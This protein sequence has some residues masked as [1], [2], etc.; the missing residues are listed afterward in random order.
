VIALAVRWYVRYRLSSADVAEWLA[1]RGIAVD[2]STV[3]RW[4]QRC[5]PRFVE[6]ARA[7]RTPVDGR[8]RVDETYGR[9]HGRW[10]SLYRAIDQNGQVVA[11]SFSERRNAE[12]ATAFFRRAIATSGVTPA[13]VTTDKAKC[14]PPALRAALPGVEHRSSKHRNTGLERDRG[15]RKQRLRPTRGCKQGA[16]ADTVSRG[17]GLVQDLRRGFSALTA[18]V[19]HPLRLAAAWPQL[20]RMI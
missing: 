5:L 15:H 12:A 11:V 16:S 19:A 3:Y 14:Y 8:W 4:V 18:S 9:L 17:H 20:A 6:A 13:R 7:H 1:E 10:A 2:R